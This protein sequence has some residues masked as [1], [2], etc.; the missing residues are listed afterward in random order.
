MARHRHWSRSQLIIDGI[1][2]RRL[3][4]TQA[5]VLKSLL[6]RGTWPGTWYWRNSSTTSKA[7]E[8]LAKR[9]LVTTELVDSTD[10]RGN[11]DP[12]GGKVTFY[13]PVKWLREAMDAP[14]ERVSELLA[15]Q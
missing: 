13:R 5:G 6:E 15:A 12:K 3:G 14:E 10:W 9:G 7:L 8:S 2:G 1:K 11:P 4:R